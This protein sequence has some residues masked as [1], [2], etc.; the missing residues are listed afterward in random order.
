MVIAPFRLPV[1]RFGVFELNTASGEL[2]KAG[3][4][5][6]LRPQACRVLV[7]LAS[8][9]GELVTR[10]ELRDEIW[11]PNEFVDFEHGLNLCIRQ[12]REALGE[13]ADAPRY[14]QTLPRRGYR[15]LGAV[16]LAK[17][18][19]RVMIAVLPFENLTGDPT[20]EYLSDGLTEEMTIELGK[21]DPEHLGVIARTSVMKY[22]NAR[23]GLR[24]I[25]REMA[26][27]YV[28]EGSVRRQENRIRVAVQ[29]IRV[30]DQTH[31]WAERF[32]RNMSD[33]LDLQA[34]VARAVAAQ[35][36][37]KLTVTQQERLGRSRSLNPEA[38]EAYMRGRLHLRKM[39]REGTEKAIKYF[40]EALAVEC[41]YAMAY[42]GM[43]DA[44][45]GITSW[46]SAPL[47]SMPKAEEAARRA[48]ELEP[49]LAQGHSLLGTVHLFFHWDWKVAEREFRR[50]IELDPNLADGHV[51]YAALLT[52]LGRFDE[53]LRELKLAQSL[54]PMSPSAHGD[55][56]WMWFGSRHYQQ[57]I[58]ESHRWL[59]IDPGSG[60]AYWTMALA[61]SY[62]GEHKAA[63]N[64][65]RRGVRL[66]DSPFA[67][68]CLAEVYARSGNASQAR[69]ELA[70]LESELPNKYVC[71]YNMA[72]VYG[73]LG[74]KDKAFESLE[75]AFLQRSD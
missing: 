2:R 52:T 25:T 7:I 23:K 8:R 35:I 69:Q 47:E 13:D 49:D 63:I 11:G 9:S 17:T 41:R 34:K 71:G 29:L 60:R 30:S 67:S 27:D 32:D 39:T 56:L 55:E 48:V 68:V 22:K 59:E 50:A 54:D 14:L 3:R 26:V 12:I 65:A 73:A 45:I 40:Q 36:D 21:L 28:L 57:A 38:H 70:N 44:H 42:A 31:L 74:D 75:R 6:R 46:Y 19:G 16:Q 5:V 33:L 37:L 62:K 20:Q 1:I 15:F 61:Y 24:A 43:A 66:S 64:A 4:L 53:A 10:D 72:A 51:G 18:D 58:T